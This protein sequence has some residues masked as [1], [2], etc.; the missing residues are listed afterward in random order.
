MLVAN[1]SSRKR[2]R[3]SA[4]TVQLSAQFRH[5]TTMAMVPTPWGMSGFLWRDRENENHGAFLTDQPQGSLLCRIWTPGLSTAELRG[6]ILRAYPLCHEV[7]GEGVCFHPEVVPDW[8]NDLVRYLQGYYTAELRGWT[9][10]QFVDNWAFWKSR[11]DWSQV[12]SFQRQVLDVVATIPS[13][14]SLSYGQ[15]AARIG[16]PSASRAVGAALGNNPWPVL[17]PCHRVVGAGGKLTGF[18]AP[19]G[20]DAKRRM[21]DM[22]QT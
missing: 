17:I 11:L 9:H 19:G 12:T 20:I 10:P 2:P 16:K 22:E 4:A 8:F 6:E 18:S 21:L 3:L 1:R 7:L 14:M 5:A 15:V 13:G